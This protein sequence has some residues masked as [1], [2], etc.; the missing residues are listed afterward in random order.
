MK[1][2][3]L[4]LLALALC[5]APLAQADE[6]PA[7]PAQAPLD[8]AIAKDKAAAEAPAAAD[9]SFD[10]LDDGK[11]PSQEQSAADAR[12]ILDI[13]KQVKLRRNMLVSHQIFGFATLAA[14]AATVVI[15]HLN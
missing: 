13:D 9:L 1:K 3:A 5:R 11:K 12:R 8:Q 14:L 4:L 6:P 10:L 7:T 15:G 2:A